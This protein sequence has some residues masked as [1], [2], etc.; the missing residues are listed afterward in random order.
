[1]TYVGV[2]LPWLVGLLTSFV[3]AVTTT[4][5]L[6]GH[7]RTLVYDTV[8]ASC[9]TRVALF[10]WRFV[11]PL[12]VFVVAYWKIIST[13]RRSVKL[14]TSRPVHES[15]ASSVATA[16]PLSDSQKNVI[17]TM[18][19][20][21]SLFIVSWLPFHLFLVLVQCGVAVLSNKFYYIFTALISVNVMLNSF[22]YATGQHPQLSPAR[23]VSRI[24]N[25]IQRNRKVGSCDGSLSPGVSIV[26]ANVA[27]HGQI[28][29]SSGETDVD[30][31]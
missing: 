28:F 3:P 13:L 22:V 6:Q 2:A 18:I 14:V 11:I 21:I 17:W 30:C 31:V 27:S 10:S 8:T 16:K 9:S 23:C 15:A 12:T 1:M 19:V 25:C 4:R 26:I 24:R 5:F 7:C 20:V 29:P